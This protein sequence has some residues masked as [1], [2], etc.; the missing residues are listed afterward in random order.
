[1]PFGVKE[2]HADEGSDERDEDGP[3]MSNKECTRAVKA[4][5]TSN[6][7]GSSDL[8]EQDRAEGG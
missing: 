8:E 4:H 3:G 7:S 5:E 2:E 6:D 1:M